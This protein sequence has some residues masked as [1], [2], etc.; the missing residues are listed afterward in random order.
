MA[1]MTPLQA[2]LAARKAKPVLTHTPGTASPVAAAQIQAERI[3]LVAPWGQHKAG[4][5]LRIWQPG[6]DLDADVVDPGRALQ[7]LDDGI[8]IEGLLRPTETKPDTK[9]KAKEG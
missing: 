3:T 2:S 4:A 9:K 1:E 6:V 5:L 8:A 7:L